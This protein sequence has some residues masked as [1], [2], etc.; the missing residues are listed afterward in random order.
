MRPCAAEPVAFAFS[1]ENLTRADA[2]ITRYPPG[3]QASA[4]LPLLDLAQRQCG[5]WLPQAAIEYV[6]EYLDMPRIRVMECA[7]FYSMFNL[8]PIGRHFVQMCRTTPCW[9][10]G[11]DDLV[12]AYQNWASSGIGETTADGQFTLIEV[13]CLGA[14]ANA[15]MVQIN[16]DFYEDLTPQSFI[17]ILEK[18]RAGEQPR[19]GSQSGRRGSA[20]APRALQG[21]AGDD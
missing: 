9:L 13:E 5:N 20:P 15:P 6:A 11:S 3:G 2:I 18:L 12:A 8:R 17:A 21:A 16:D 4:V 14:C 10:C 19:T 7:T 1:A